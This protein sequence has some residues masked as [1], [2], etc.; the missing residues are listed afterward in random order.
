M[1]FKT[2]FCDLSSPLK[3]NNNFSEINTSEKFKSS[4]PILSPPSRFY[5]EL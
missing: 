4:V 5:I 1:Q 3:F 2:E